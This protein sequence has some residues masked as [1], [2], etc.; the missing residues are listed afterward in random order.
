[1]FPQT[2]NPI[3]G[4]LLPTN[5]DET[6]LSES[7]RK[8]RYTNTDNTYNG[9]K[10]LENK[11]KIDGIGIFLSNRDSIFDDLIFPIL[12][13]DLDETKTARILVV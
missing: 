7:T 1:M 8:T 9:L 13:A 12:P 6:I 11:I 2:S 3:F 4:P 10:V 5:S